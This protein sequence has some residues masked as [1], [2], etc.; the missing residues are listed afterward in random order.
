MF[1]YVFRNICYCKRKQIAISATVCGVVV[2]QPNCIFRWNASTFPNRC[3]A[4]RI[5]F[6]N[7]AKI[8]TRF[9]FHQIRSTGKL[10]S[11]GAH[12]YVATFVSCKLCVKGTLMPLIFNLFCK[13][14]RPN[15]RSLKQTPL[16]YFLLKI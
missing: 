11:Y 8:N 12:T 6:L 2:Y 3:K 7:T 4:S 15:T 5:V 10:T 13:A 16:F 1:H 9:S 14:W